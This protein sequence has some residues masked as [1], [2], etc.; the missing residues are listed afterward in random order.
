MD[1]IRA[2][3]R[4]FEAGLAAGA[5]LLGCSV[6]QLG[7]TDAN[8]AK[9]RSQVATGGEL[10]NR[11]CATCHGQRG[12]GLASSPAV[13]GPSALPLYTRDP[14]TS[15]NPALQDPAEQQ[16]DQNLPAGADTRGAFETAADLYR[17]TSREMPLPRSKAGSLKPEE[18]WAIVNYMLVAHGVAVPEGGV[19]E[20][21]AAS[22]PLRP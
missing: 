12:E 10:F 4:C 3:R 8:L 18:Y 13:M 21:N 5:L 9:A 7:A 6:T 22:V 20:T 17:Y 11:E 2:P 16:R 15:T 19:N 1:R 14:K